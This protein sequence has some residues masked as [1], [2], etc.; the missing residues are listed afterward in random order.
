MDLLGSLFSLPPSP[1]RVLHKTFPN[2]THHDHSFLANYGHL[3]H[4]LQ[5]LPDSQQCCDYLG[6][7]CGL[8]CLH[9]SPLLLGRM[10]P[11]ED[12]WKSDW[13][14]SNEY[15][16]QKN[17]SCWE[18]VERRIWKSDYWKVGT[19]WQPLLLLLYHYPRSLRGVFHPQ[20]SCHAAPNSGIILPSEAMVNTLIFLGWPPWESLFAGTT[21]FWTPSS[22]SSSEK[23]TGSGSKAFSTIQSWVLCIVK[24]MSDCL[25][26]INNIV[27]I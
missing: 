12:L 27:W 8:G 17:R 2:R 19:H 10:L 14:I 6:C 20:R 22:P 26:F 13:T 1:W 4:L 16:L 9:T 7:D 5:G 24:S 25:S 23:P 11:Q 3:R 21:S 15:R 18:E